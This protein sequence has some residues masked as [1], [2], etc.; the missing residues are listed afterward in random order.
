MTVAGVKGS[1]GVIKHAG[2]LT[3][4]SFINQLLKLRDIQIKHL[5]NQS[6]RKNILP[7]ILGSAANRLDGQSGYGNPQ[8]VMIFLPLSLWLDVV[9]IVQNNATLLE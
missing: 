2:V 6:K 9:G 8:V 5:C 1:Q 3:A 4:K 7:L